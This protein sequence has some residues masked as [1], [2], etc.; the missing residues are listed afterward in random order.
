[1]SKME[2]VHGGK[3]VTFLFLVLVN[4]CACLCV[5][6]LLLLLFC[7]YWGFD[8]RVLKVSGKGCSIRTS[9]YN[10]WVVSGS[11]HFL[12]DAVTAVLI[13]LIVIFYYLRLI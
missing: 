5:F 6:Y 12:L 10:N 13:F 4:K 3:F 2:A 7:H 11:I 9:F 8:V 1:M